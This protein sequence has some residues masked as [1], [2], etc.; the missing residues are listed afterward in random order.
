MSE[1]AVQSGRGPWRAGLRATGQ[2]AR[3]TPATTGLEARRALQLGL[4]GL[5]LLDG[6]LQYQPFMYTRAFGQMLAGTAAGN[7]A[8]V[9]RPITWQAGLAGHHLVL[10]NTIF[11]TIQLLLGL[12]IAIRPTARPALAA[13][14]AWSLGVWWLGEGLG[15]V[16]SGRASPL[17]GAPGAALLYALLA[18]LLWPAGRETPAPF[19]AAR[20][21]GPHVAR[22][23]WLALWG[24]LAYLALTPASR[25][26]GAVSGLIAAMADGEPGWLA[27]LIHGAAALVTGADLATSAG[28]AVALAVVAVGIWLPA[29]AARATLLLGIAV[30]L[31]IWVLAQGLG[32]ILAGGATDP[33]SGPLLVL[34][35]LAYWPARTAGKAARGETTP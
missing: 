35:A 28:L 29:A 34:L 10:A 14:V 27:A 12:G 2:A 30:A 17:S 5:W 1:A 24:S 16:L 33:N 15:G 18:V 7:P 13:S 21:A 19:T 4:A 22:A 8:I 3:R 9:A 23:L 6:V 11:A 26:P 20:A 31:V 32:G 25:A